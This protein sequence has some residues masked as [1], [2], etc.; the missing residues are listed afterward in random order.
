MA[1]ERKFKD[2]NE[3]SEFKP[4]ETVKDVLR[5]PIKAIP[6]RGISKDVCE[7]LGIRSAISESD[8]KTVT[9]L[10]FPYHDQKG[11]ICGFKKRDLTLDKSEK[12][13][14]TAVGTVSV[15]CKL[16]GQQYAESVNRKR[17][18]LIYVEG[19]LDVAAS[20]QA[21]I[22]SVKGT[23][24]EDLRPFIVGLSCG[25]ANAIEATL[26]NEHFIRSFSKITLGMDA[27][28]ATPTEKKKGIK[29][30]K[31]AMED[32]AGAIIGDNLYSVHYEGAHKDPS[33]YLQAGEGNSL[34]KLLQFGAKRFVTEKIAYASD[35]SFE[36]LIEKRKPGLMC[37]SFPK[38]MEKINGFRKSE[39]VLLTSGVGVGKSTVTSSFAADFIAA[40][41]RVGLIFLEETKKETLQRMV[42]HALKVNYNKFKA[43]PLS[44]ASK[45]DI[46]AAYENIVEDDKAVFLDHFG[47]LPISELMNKIKHMHMVS[48]CSYVI[49][50][51]IT[52][53]TSGGGGDEDE[54][55]QIDRAMTE[56]AAYCAS[57]DVCIIA[58]SHINR[59]G[60]LDNK[61]PK[62]ADEKPYWVKVDKSHMRG[63]SA[64]EALSWIILGLEGQVMPDR[65]R[66]N[67]RLTCL[68]NRP[69]G[70][71]GVCDEFRLNPETWAVELQDTDDLGF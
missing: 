13:H 20:L 44:V 23:K 52:L 63:S 64:L 21:M 45:E 36:E 65:S 58:I 37:P 10:Y 15:T 29:R 62:D 31:E 38:L 1:Y 61:P 34:A 39:L 6:E 41:E 30:G 47:H 11:N 24:F 43:D 54:R 70:L 8:G 27:D 68:K 51:H 12:G 60:F 4:K 33:D 49:L 67:V 40:G 57:H 18:N 25:T 2:Y 59:G 7:L 71:L 26:H 42:A 9:A 19:E 55:R 48:K 50:D 46:Q 35:V 28:E 66:G 17:A 16:F 3:V 5:Y 69:F 22:D 53:V 56:L 14:F 32:I